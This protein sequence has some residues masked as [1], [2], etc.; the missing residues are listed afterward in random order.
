MQVKGL[1]YIDNIPISIDIKGSIIHRISKNE[2]PDTEAHPTVYIAPGFIDHQVNGYF[3]HSFVDK[4]LSIEKVQ[5]ITRKLRE[6]GVTTYYPTLITSSRKLL[7]RNLAI[8]AEAGEDPDTQLSIPGF[9]LE[10]P[11]IS[12]L[13][14]FHGAHLKKWIKDPDWDEFTALYHASGQKIREITIAPELNGSIDFI[15]RCCK[16]NIVVGLGHHNGTSDIIKKAIDAGARVATHLGN[17]IANYIHHHE[18]PIWPQLADERLMA[19]LIVDGFH[20][21]PEEVQVF[22]KVKG[23]ENVT[24]VSDVS[25]LGG[26]KPGRYNDLV[27]TKD[28]MVYFPAQNV[29]AGASLLI[30]KGIENIIKYTSCTLAESIHMASR[31]PARLLGLK[32]R[33]ILKAGK[34]ADLVLFTIESGKIKLIKTM[35]AGKI[36]FTEHSY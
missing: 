17:G 3:G 34:R 18:N 22:L 23:P 11:Y 30:I 1:S 16:E 2:E 35:L 25:K 20:L 15:R 36:V 4:D 26:L 33:G 9:H 8:L 14:E 29:K 21:T 19:S 10:G 5:L 6:N 32:D 12:P 7:L 13:D 24:L 27:L 31:N 28:G